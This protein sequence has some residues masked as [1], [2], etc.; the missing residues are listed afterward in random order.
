MAGAVTAPSPPCWG[1]NDGSGGSAA[2]PRTDGDGAGE[3]YGESDAVE[4]AADAAAESTEMGEPA[5]A[6]RMPGAAAAGGASGTPHPGDAGRCVK[7]VVAPVVDALF[8]TTRDSSAAT[9]R[10]VRGKACAG[11]SND[12][13]DASAASA[14]AVPTIESMVK[15]EEGKDTVV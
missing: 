14:A 5:P 7:G 11:T 12:S 8:V 4:D 15:G 9:R 3:P 10:R 1:V 2:Y 13:A 6:V